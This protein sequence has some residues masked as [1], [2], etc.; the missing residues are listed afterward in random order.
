V[1][2]A[3]RFVALTRKETRQMVRDRSN[4]LVG[5]LL[6][7]VL[8]VLYGYGLSFDVKDARVTVVLEDAS[9]TARSA[10]AGLEGSPYLAPVF[11]GTRSDAER[12]MRAGRTDAILIVPEDYSRRLAS[13]NASMELL[14]NGVDA[15]TAATIEGYVSG[16]IAIPLQR[17]ADRG[18]GATSGTG[19]VVVDQRMWFNEA[20]ESTWY[21]VPGLIV[22]VMTLIG[23]FLTSLLVAREWERGTLESLFVTPVRPLEIVLAKLTPYLVVGAIDLAVCLAM[24]KWLFHVPMR[25]SLAVVVAASLLYLIVSLSLGLLI[26]ATTRNQFTASQLAMLTSFM[27]AMMLSGFVFDLRNVPEVIQVVSNVLPAT[28]FMSLIK[29]LFL[30]GDNAPAAVRTCSILALFAVVLVALCRRALKKRL[31]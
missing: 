8:I 22:L 10:I 7:I 31:D 27:P 16:A 28:H 9:P 14:L 6:P 2:F 3:T 4:L 20:G 25:G 21:L 26:S 12:A 11:V 30:T 5:L 23:A 17:D 19:S 15:T 1:S 24:A 13:G 29:T 18:G